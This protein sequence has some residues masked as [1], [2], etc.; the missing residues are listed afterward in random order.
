[1]GAFPPPQLQ[2]KLAL[3][4]VQQQR[5]DRISL[6]RSGL[7]IIL[8]MSL[9]LTATLPYWKIKQST[10][11]KI[12]GKKLVSEDTVRTAINFNYPQFI[13]TVNGLNIARKIESIPSIAAVK[14]NKQI[15]PP[16]LIISLQE[17][18][19]VA[20]ATSQGKIGFLDAN[21]EWIPQQFYTNIDAKSSLPKLKV[22]DHQP[23]Y[24][25]PWRKIYQLVSLYPE[26]QI[27]EIQWQDSGSL[28]IQTKIG[29]VFL[30]SD[31]SQLEL[32]FKTMAK[33][34]NLPDYLESSEIA[35]IDLSNPQVN[36]IQKY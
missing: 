15:I 17:K 8:A 26:L 28:F 21:G 30:G 20:I 10:Q 3:V 27:S 35:Y 36:L 34:A 2:Y 29:R 11:I 13:G 9:G 1:M 14:V 4:K 22:I 32:Q 5:L 33:L 16:H 6:W 7:I 18:E 19:P 24:Q 12:K 23:S 25:Q 31:R